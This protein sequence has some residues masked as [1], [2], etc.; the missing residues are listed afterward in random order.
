MMIDVFRL[1][2]SVNSWPSYQAPTNFY[3]CRI[4]ISDH[5][6]LSA[7]GSRAAEPVNKSAPSME[8]VTLSSTQQ[9][10]ERFYQPERQHHYKPFLRSPLCDLRTGHDVIGRS[11]APSGTMPFSRYLHISINSLLATATM[12]ILRIRLPPDANRR[13]YHRVN[14]LLG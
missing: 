9:F 14:L 5:L 1:V 3:P 12:P 10:L 2:G 7:L 13:L 4:F 8:T 6:M 11:R